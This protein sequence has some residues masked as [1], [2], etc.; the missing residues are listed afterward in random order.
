VLEAAKSVAEKIRQRSGLV[1]DGVPLVKQAF[2]IPKRSYP[3]LAFNALQTVS[4]KSE[5]DGLAN[6]MKGLFGAFRN[7]T[8]HQP[9]H[10]WPVT[11]QDALDLLTIVSLIHRRLDDA[12]STGRQPP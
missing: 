3:L 8:A 6:L 4:E 5:H 1:S 7:P 11:E 2:D 9:E 10:T 12:V